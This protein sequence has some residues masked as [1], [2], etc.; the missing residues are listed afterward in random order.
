MSEPLTLKNFILNYPAR[1]YPIADLP[2]PDPPYSNIPLDSLI[3]N[4]LYT[5]PYLLGFYITDLMDCFAYLIPANLQKLITP[6]MTPTPTS[7]L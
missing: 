7:S 5:N 6:C 2:V 1:A 4:F 3:G